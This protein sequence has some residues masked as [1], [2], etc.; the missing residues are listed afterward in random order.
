LFL[1][2]DQSGVTVDSIKRVQRNN[3]RL[4]EEEDRWLD[5]NII[6]YQFD[7]L[8]NKYDLDSIIQKCKFV[9]PCFYN[10][11]IANKKT[12]TTD[13]DDTDVGTLRDIFQSDY[14]FVPISGA[15]HWSLC[16]LCNVFYYLIKEH[17]KHLKDQT[18]FETIFENL[19]SND[20]P[21][22]ILFLNSLPGFHKREDVRKAITMYLT[23]YV[24]KEMQKTDKN[25]FLPDWMSSAQK[26]FFLDWIEEELFLYKDDSEFDLFRHLPSPNSNLGLR[27]TNGHD[28]GYYVLLNAEHFINKIN[29]STT[30]YQALDTLIKEGMFHNWFTYDDLAIAKSE[31]L[32]KLVNTI[33]PR[34][35]VENQPYQDQI[36]AYLHPKYDSSII[37]IEEE[38][39]KYSKSLLDEQEYGGKFKSVTFQSENDESIQKTEDRDNCI[40]QI[41]SLLEQRKELEIQ[42]MEIKKKQ[43]AFDKIFKD[44]C[45]NTNNYFRVAKNLSAEDKQLLKNTIQASDFDAETVQDIYSDIIQTTVLSSEF[46][47]FSQL[48]ADESTNKS[49]QEG[50]LYTPSTQESEDNVDSTQESYISKSDKNKKK[51]TTIRTYTTRANH[52][53]TANYDEEFI[54]QHT[55]PLFTL[56]YIE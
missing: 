42:A 6:L 52:G 12:T 4:L 17:H 50:S 7:E 47:T 44:Y 38:S 5:D 45:S 3:L 2:D 20:R 51:P 1:G 48:S 41:Q 28:C 49:S 15:G 16:I 8:R 18:I 53:S 24:K 40:S 31:L 11:K 34:I 55:K 9:H 32:K 10:G 36:C 25:T 14:V 13:D 39:L 26:E 23:N 30:P 21:T 35:Y 33:L 27:Q 22:C 19:L 29:N 37:T 46:L 56:F 54:Q 43:A